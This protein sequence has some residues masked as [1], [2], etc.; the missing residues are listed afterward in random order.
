MPDGYPLIDVDMGLGR[1]HGY[2][3]P[4][5]RLR[6]RAVLAAEPDRALLTLRELEVLQ[7]AAW[8]RPN[9]VIARQLHVSSDTVKTLLSRAYRKLDA[10]DR[11]QAVAVAV[12]R[13]LISATAV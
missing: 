12:A 3:D 9:R 8:G 2:R 1:E 10:R 5:R 6:G 11:A 4:F 7:L 13:G